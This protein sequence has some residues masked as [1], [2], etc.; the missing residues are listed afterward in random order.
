M[1]SVNVL[2]GIKDQ[3]KVFVGKSHQKSTVW[4][5][6]E[7]HH[8]LGLCSWPAATKS[9]NIVLNTLDEISHHLIVSFNISGCHN[10]GK[11]LFSAIFFQR[12]SNVA[13]SLSLQLWV[14][15]FASLLESNVK[16]KILKKQRFNYI[17]QSHSRTTQKYRK[18]SSIYLACNNSA[19]LSVL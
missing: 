5:Q 15:L 16:R 8:D 13:A 1:V 11:Q 12:L 2:G 19:A 3:Q 14:F 18:S 17:F 10:C 6:C 4:N 7:D 9:F